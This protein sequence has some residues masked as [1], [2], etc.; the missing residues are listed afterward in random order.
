[1]ALN[2]INEL[3]R[4]DRLMEAARQQEGLNPDA[5]ELFLTVVR[6]GDA[7]AAVENQYLSR[8]GI[9]P[10]RF[11][12]MML[13][14][15]EEGVM[16]KPSQLAESTGVTRATMTGLLDT[17]ERDKMV[18]RSADPK[19]RRALRVTATPEGKATFREL[20]PGYFRLV[21]AIPAVLNDK[22]RVQYNALSKKIREGLKL[23]DAQF[24]KGRKNGSGP[25]K[26]VEA[27]LNA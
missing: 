23:A 19:D 20:L 26:A 15:M 3:P 2:E 13:L 12:V 17:L 8:H 5:C 21:T 6:T 22:E 10:G 24:G 7:V 4:Y 16:L 27:A 11:A 9:T 1:M 18:K 25:V 14:S